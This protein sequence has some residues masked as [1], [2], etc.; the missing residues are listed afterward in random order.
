VFRY[1]IT[2]ALRNGDNHLR[3]D[4]TNA[5]ANRLIGDHELLEDER[6][7]WTTAND[8]LEGEPLLA[9]GL[10]GPVVLAAE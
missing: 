6:L 2:G 3:I 8:A 10:L 7:T 9:A 4:V 1:W 5:W